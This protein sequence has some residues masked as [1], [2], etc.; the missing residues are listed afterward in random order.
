[1]SHIKELK[2][3][4]QKVKIYGNKQQVEMAYSS[5]ETLSLTGNEGTDRLLLQ[6]VMDF[7]KVKASISYNGNG[8][9]SFD[10]IIRNY[11]QMK[12]TGTLE[13]MSD[14]FYRFLYLDCDSI[15][16]YDKHGWIECYDNSF[17]KLQQF[18]RGN[19][20]GRDVIS[21]MPH[22]KTDA[23]RIAKEI[24]KDVLI[25][26]MKETMTTQCTLFD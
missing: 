2:I 23:I 17:E 5:I 3:K 14:T 8:I 1:M 16:H 21:C 6:E 24:M 7:H 12:K 9:V 15:A 26:N 11:K 18:F 22:W 20:M 13:K 4:N 10:K 25:E 19:E